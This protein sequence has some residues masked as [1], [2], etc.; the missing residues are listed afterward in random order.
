MT[1]ANCHYF[2][3]TRFAANGPCQLVLRNSGAT[4]QKSIE[5]HIIAACCKFCSGHFFRKA[6]LNQTIKDIW[7]WFSFRHSRR[8]Q[9][10][11]VPPML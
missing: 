6:H 8:T 2:V 11:I 7:R 4:R 9:S 5:C 10:V 3:D 1:L